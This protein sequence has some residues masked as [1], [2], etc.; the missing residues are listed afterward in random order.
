MCIE[1]AASVSRFAR[2]WRERR[3]IC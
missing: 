1:A 3:W 2:N